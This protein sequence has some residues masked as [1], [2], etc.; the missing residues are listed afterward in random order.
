MRNEDGLKVVKVDRL[1]CRRRIVKH[2]LSYAGHILSRSS[3][4]NILL[5]LE[6][7]LYGKK[8]RGRSRRMWINDRYE[9]SVNETCGEV[10]RPAADV[11][12]WRKMLQFP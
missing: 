8:A 11:E 2:K 9:W 7:K 3:G 1:Q 10:K 6:G 12:T 5:I 4:D